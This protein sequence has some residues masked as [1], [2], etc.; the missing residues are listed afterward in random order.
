M[1]RRVFLKKTAGGMAKANLVRFFWRRI[2]GG[3][4][5]EGKKTGGG[6]RGV[7][8]GGIKRGKKGHT[9]EQKTLITSE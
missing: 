7:R 6:R 2:W 4:M 9:V 8:T 5:G 1:K 3:S